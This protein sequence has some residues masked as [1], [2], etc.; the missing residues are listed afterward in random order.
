MILNTTSAV[1]NELTNAESNIS[2]LYEKIAQQ[3]PQIR[4]FFL[5]YSNEN[6]KNKII[7]QRAYY[8][9]NKDDL[10]AES[11]F[12]K[13]LDTSKYSLKKTFPIS[14]TLD[15]IFQ[16]AVESEKTTIQLYSDT[17]KLSAGIMPYLH[18]ILQ[19]LIEKRGKR[20]IK[21]EK[22]RKKLTIQSNDN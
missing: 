7:I 20:I 22:R 18:D 13:G 19:T 17:A 9:K 1:I 4:E 3:Y 10:D 16:I 6:R 14:S 8:A 5:V 11:V 2:I 12:K 15:D 21:I